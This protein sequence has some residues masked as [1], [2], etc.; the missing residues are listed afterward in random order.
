[1]TELR[2]VSV[3]GSA[4]L[5]ENLG[6]L[7]IAEAAPWDLFLELGDR[8]YSSTGDDLFE[9]LTSLRYAL[10]G[11]GLLICVEGARADVYPSGMSRQMG[12]GRRAY[13]H[14]AGRRPSRADLVDVFD[15]TPC[16]EVVGVDAQLA[17]ITQLRASG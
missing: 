9:S 11:D 3:V 7:G 14:V 2:Q 5:A 4:A 1:M 8:R 16:E 6:V 10:E 13:R 17:S 12:G 15:A